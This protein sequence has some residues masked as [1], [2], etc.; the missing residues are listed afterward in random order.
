MPG[1]SY[2]DNTLEVFFKGVAIT[3]IYIIWRKF[4]SKAYEK[5][6]QI[7]FTSSEEVTWESDTKVMCEEC[8]EYFSDDEDELV[9]GKFLCEPCRDDI[10]RDH[11]E[12]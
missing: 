8:K 1:I 7:L 12:K 9:H 10:I 4:T 2:L 6:H 3:G 5:V 11:L